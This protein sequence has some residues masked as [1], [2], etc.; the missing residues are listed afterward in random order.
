MTGLVIGLVVGSVLGHAINVLVKRLRHEELAGPTDDPSDE[1]CTQI[2]VK[3]A[4]H[5]DHMR[6]QVSTFA[7]E[8]AGD[9]VLLRAR[10]RMFERGE[11]A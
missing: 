6:S 1:A 7:D 2:D 3:L 11:A 4:A 8:L 10:L 5:V 9:D